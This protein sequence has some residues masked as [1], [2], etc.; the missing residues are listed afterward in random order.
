MKVTALIENTNAPGMESLKVEHG[1]SLYIEYVG[2]RILFDT[3]ES[4]AF[5]DNA[6]Q[7]GVDIAVVDMVVLSHHHYDHGGGL[8]RFLQLNQKAKIYLRGRAFGDCYGKFLWLEKYIGLDPK[9]L[10]EHPDR[11]VFVNEKTTIM[12]GVDILTDVAPTYP[13]PRGNRSI[14][15]KVDGKLELDDFSH[16]LILVLHE[17]DGLGVFTGCAH[18]GVLNMVQA[19]TKVFPGSAIKA[20][21]GGFHLMAMPPFNFMSGSKA[22]VAE[23]GRKLLGFPVQRVYT[24]HCTGSHAYPVLKDAMGEKLEYIGTGRNVTV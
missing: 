6:I 9:L 22:E 16:E 3:G 19:V 10:E 24:C 14:F 5:A 12:D 17:T 11:F 13:A 20:V 23:L 1:L 7:L 18:Q 15:V 21:F 4:G 8:R 2:K